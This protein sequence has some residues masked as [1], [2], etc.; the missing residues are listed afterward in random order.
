MGNLQTNQ[1][2]ETTQPA[3]RTS[4]IVH[5]KC[6]ARGQTGPRLRSRKPVSAQNS[7]MHGIFSRHGFIKRGHGT[8]DPADFNEILAER[9]RHAN[10]RAERERLP[11]AIPDVP[12]ADLLIRY[13]TMLMRDRDRAIKELDHLKTWGA[14]TRLGAGRIECRGEARRGSCHDGL[15]SRYPLWSLHP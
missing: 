4:D 13:E 9:H 12:D 14:K 7:L 3:A 10:S 5:R 15:P 11:Y 6:A 8:E 2:P 1:V